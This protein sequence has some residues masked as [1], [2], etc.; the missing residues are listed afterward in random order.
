MTEF[1]TPEQYVANHKLAFRIAF[2]FLSK[3]FP[4][5][6]TEEWGEKVCR[7]VAD[8]ALAN[9]GDELTAQLLVAVLNYL[10]LENE[11]RRQEETAN[12]AEH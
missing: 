8:A 12:A 2:N 10:D 11:K 7:N 1:P 6:N 4:P 5:E 3:H 9:P